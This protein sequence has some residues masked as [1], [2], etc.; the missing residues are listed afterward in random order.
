M[1]SAELKKQMQSE[2]LEDTW[3][4]ELDGH[5][6]EGMFTLRRAMNIPREIDSCLKVLH[7]SY[8]REKKSGWIDLS[9]EEFHVP[10]HSKRKKLRKRLSKKIVRQLLLMFTLALSAFL[11]VE[12]RDF[13]FGSIFGSSGEI[14]YGEADEDYF[15]EE[16]R[17]PSVRAEVAK[18]GRILYVYNTSKNEWP[19]GVVYFDSPDGF[20]YRFS[21]RIPPNE[22]LQIPLRNFRKGNEV[23]D[24]ST[25][26]VSKVGIEVPGMENW[27]QPFIR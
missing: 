17:L 2:G 6:L 10:H 13:D 15:D 25:V 24:S 12:F 14:S 9:F 5:L 16:G 20:V 18:T 22:G 4:V 26:K 11:Y 21:A 19:S 27:E 7:A 8:P 23:F 1:K 3:W